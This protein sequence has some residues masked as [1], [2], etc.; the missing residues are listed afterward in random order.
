M[1]SKLPRPW[2]DR[3]MMICLR[4]LLETLDR[5]NFVLA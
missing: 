1:S 4:S 2:M 5:S 3:A